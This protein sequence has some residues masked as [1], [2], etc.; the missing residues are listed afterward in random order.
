MTAAALISLRETLE[1]SLV[2]GLILTLLVRLQQRGQQRYVWLGVGCGIALSIVVAVLFQVFAA[3][4]TDE[5]KE[6]YEGCM[7][8]AGAGLLTWMIFWMMRM[9]SKV[10]ASIERDVTLYA[11]A[12]ESFPL[13]LLS[14]TTTAREGTEL[15]L[16]L[17]AAFLSA[18]SDL[19]SL[20]GAL[21]GVTGALLLTFMI[22]RSSRKFSLSA[23]FKVTGVFLLLFAAGLVAHGIGALQ[24]AGFF[25]FLQAHVWDTRV[26]LPEETLVGGVLESLIGYS[27]HPT[28]LQLSAYVLY[29]A[30]AFLV[31][32]QM[33]RQ[34]LRPK[35]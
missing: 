21:A 24:E 16:F 9:G 25:T 23:F 10:R 5:A 13:F 15:V 6:L 11:M 14:F 28:V 27:D 32:Q 7:M 26:V 30:G 35:P 1:T 34:T 31:W 2:I 33:T 3:T 18:K 4:L 22:F 19:H 17:N 8:L 20:A 29:L 12:G